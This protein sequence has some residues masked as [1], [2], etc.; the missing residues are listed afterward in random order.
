MKWKS[1]TQ[2]IA[3]YPDLFS[4]DDLAALAESYNAS[5]NEVNNQVN[6]V[7]NSIYSA[8]NANAM[9]DITDIRTIRGM[10]PTLL[11]PDKRM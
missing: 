10:N 5:L 6:A 11:C 4:Q 3:L 7:I 1:F 9:Q 2:L 8:L